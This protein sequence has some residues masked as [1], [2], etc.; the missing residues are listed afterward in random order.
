MPFIDTALKLES[1]PVGEAR[2]VQLGDVQVGVF[3]EKEGLFAIDNYCPHRSA[4]M[5][6]GFVKDGVVTC[7]WHQWQFRLS[8]GVCLNIPGARTA[9]YPLEVREGKIWINLEGKAVKKI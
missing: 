7:P 6:D 4:P 8:D 3:H 5:H 9:T 1:V 2:S